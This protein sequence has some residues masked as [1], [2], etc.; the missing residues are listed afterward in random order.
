MTMP[1]TVS[2]PSGAMFHGSAS[3]KGLHIF[4]I[5]AKTAPNLVKTWNRGTMAFCPTAAFKIIFCLFLYREGRENLF[6]G[7][8]KF[9]VYGHLRR[10]LCFKIS[11]I[12][13]QCIFQVLEQI[14]ILLCII[15]QPTKIMNGVC[16]TSPGCLI[17]LVPLLNC[18]IQPY[19][20]QILFDKI[21]MML[22]LVD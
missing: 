14:S 15:Q 17:G 6:L 3:W 10:N 9:A 7:K 4:W 11:D 18:F 1:L 16:T 12:R 19:I 5:A 21:Q 22:K 20:S 13:F 2:K 8:N